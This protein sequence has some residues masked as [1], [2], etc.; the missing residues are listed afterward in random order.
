MAFLGIDLGTGGIRCLLVDESGS[1]LADVSRSISKINLS[2]H[3][4][5][6]EQSADEWIMLL[7]DA[8]DELFSVPDQRNLQAIAVDS[9]SGTV[10]PVSVDGKALGC[11]LLHNEIGRAHV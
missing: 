7:N 3:P 2:S 9:T 6:S 8:L 1:I 10:L 4:G 5:H 11:A